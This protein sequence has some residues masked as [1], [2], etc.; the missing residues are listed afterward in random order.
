[1]HIQEAAGPKLKPM[2][3]KEAVDQMIIQ[4]DWSKSI[5]FVKQTLGELRKEVGYTF[6]LSMHLMAVYE[7][8][9]YCYGSGAF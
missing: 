6:S 9:P 1:M 8:F 2:R 3:T 7:G 5:P 4:S